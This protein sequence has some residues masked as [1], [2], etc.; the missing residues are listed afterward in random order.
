MDKSVNILNRWLEP[1]EQSRTPDNPLQGIPV[2]TGE[3]CT[4]TFDKKCRAKQIEV[5][6]VEFSASSERWLG[7]EK[8]RYYLKLYTYPIS[9]FDLNY[10]LISWAI[11]KYCRYRGMAE[12]L[13][14]PQTE[15]LLGNALNECVFVF[16]RLIHPFRDSKCLGYGVWVHSIFSGFIQIW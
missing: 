2:S 14:T 16:G 8:N 9:Y 5:K 13:V 4:I 12:E 3:N 7:L 1:V 10:S 6:C 11:C 15:N